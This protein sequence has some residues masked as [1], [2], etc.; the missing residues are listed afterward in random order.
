MADA[1]DDR[2]SNPM[3]EKAKLSHIDYLRKTERRKNS[4]QV[5]TK[6][7]MRR[8]ERLERERIKKQKEEQLALIKANEV[9]YD[10]EG[11]PIKVKKSD[12]RAISLKARMKVAR[13]L[14]RMYNELDEEDLKEQEEAAAKEKREKEKAAALRAKVKD[15]VDEGGEK[16]DEG[17]KNETDDHANQ[18][19]GANAIALQMQK[20]HL[21]QAANG[22][23]KARAKEERKKKEAAAKRKKEASEKKLQEVKLPNAIPPGSKKGK[24][25]FGVV[26]KPYAG[27]AFGTRGNYVEGMVYQ[28]RLTRSKQ[29]RGGVLAQFFDAGKSFKPEEEE[30]EDDLMSIEATDH[31]ALQRCAATLFNLSK[32]KQNIQG[33]IDEG[34]IGALVSLG[35]NDDDSICTLVAGAFANMSATPFASSKIIN[36]NATETIVALSHSRNERVRQFCCKAIFNLTRMPGL[37]ANLVSQGILGPI[38][39]LRGDGKEASHTCVS[40]VFNLSCVSSTY[41]RME[42]VVQ[43]T[44]TIV[45]AINEGVQVKGIERYRDELLLCAKAF[46]NYSK[47]EGFRVRLMEEGLLHP[48]FN[49]C[50]IADDNETKELC[51]GV[52]FDLSQSSRNRPAMIREKTLPLLLELTAL[53]NESIKQNCAGALSQ[54]ALSEANQSNVIS[55]GLPILLGLAKS[56]NY[57]TLITCAN[58]LAVLSGTRRGC[59]RLV[60]AGAIEVLVGMIKRDR[61]SG[62][63]PLKRCITSG[64]G[65]LLQQNTTDDE[66]LRGIIPILVNLCRL[67]DDLITEECVIVL[68]K[69]SLRKAV[70]DALSQSAAVEVLFDILR[71]A[72]DET[73]TQ[74][75]AVSTVCNIAA[76]DPKQLPRIKATGGI[77]ILLRL[78]SSPT[79]RIQEDC[80]QTLC[81][82]ADNGD[83]AREI[84][85]AGLSSLIA[86]A[87]G[88]GWVTKQWCSAILCS[89]SF[90][91]STRVAQ[92]DAGVRNALITLSHFKDQEMAERCATAF[93]NLTCNPVAADKI[94]DKDTIKTLLSLGGA[95]SEE[96][97]ASCARSLCNLSAR[98]G[99]EKLMV[100][101][102]TVPDLM[103]MAL[104]RSESRTTKR[105]CAKT[106]MNILVPETMESMFEYGV[107][108]AFSS[109]AKIELTEGQSHDDGMVLA[110]ATAFHNIS[111]NPTGRDRILGDKVALQAIF[112][113][114]YEGNHNVKDI[115]WKTLWNIIPIQERHIDLIDARLLHR[116][117]N[118]AVDAQSAGAQQHYHTSGNGMVEQVEDAIDLNDHVLTMIFNLIDEDNSRTLEKEELM[119]A[120]NDNQQVLELLHTSKILRPLLKPELYEE[121]FLH[122]E[123]AHEG[124]VTYAEFKSFI[125]TVVT[126]A[127]KKEERDNKRKRRS[128]L[129]KQGDENEAG[130]YS[131]KVDDGEKKT[132]LWE[133]DYV[134]RGKK[135]INHAAIENLHVCLRAK[136]NTKSISAVKKDPHES[137][138]KPNTIVY[139]AY[140]GSDML[141]DEAAHFMC[142][143]GDDNDTVTFQSSYGPYLSVNSSDNALVSSFS[144][145]TSE[146]FEIISGEADEGEVVHLYCRAVDKFV[147]AIDESGFSET[148]GNDTAFEVLTPGWDYE[149]QI[150]EAEAHAK[151]IMNNCAKAIKCLARNSVNCERL[152]AEG[153]MSILVA[154]SRAKSSETKL[155]ISATI[156]MFAEHPLTR[157]T[158]VAEGAMATIE[159]LSKTQNLQILEN[160]AKTL[161]MLSLH[162]ENAP[163]VVQQGFSSIMEEMVH[164]CSQNL[165]DPKVKEIAFNIIRTIQ[166]ISRVESVRLRMIAEEIIPTV[167][168]ALDIV[169]EKAYVDVIICITNFAELRRAR[170]SIVI[171]GATEALVKIGLNAKTVEMQQRVAIVV[172]Y[173]SSVNSKS[174][175]QAMVFSNVMKLIAVLARGERMETKECISD[176]IASLSRTKEVRKDMV[177]QGALELVQ[178]LAECGSEVAR[179]NCALTMTKIST[180]VTRMETG[181]V[182]TL[183]DL[184][185][186][187]KAKVSTDEKSGVIENLETDDGAIEQ[188]NAVMR[189]PKRV[190]MP[191]KVE[192]DPLSEEAKRIELEAVQ[193]ISWT[194]IA[195]NTE[196]NPPALPDF[197]GTEKEQKE[198]EKLSRGIGY[199]D[200]PM[201]AS[202]DNEETHLSKYEVIYKKVEN[203]GHSIEKALGT[204]A[205]NDEQMDLHVD[206]SD[207]EGEEKAAN[208]S[209]LSDLYDSKRI[210]VRSRSGVRGSPRSSVGDS[211]KSPTLRKK[212][213]FSF[214]DPQQLE[215]E[216]R[217][218][219]GKT[220]PRI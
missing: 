92:V 66:T 140:H 163:V 126:A 29:K 150:A 191:P 86:L 187:P 100:E 167:L 73:P 12:K 89:L 136:A 99:V 160:C 121:A 39:Q 114:L 61:E 19:A 199:R 109:L 135:I 84:V 72:K 118:L 44:I 1:D 176:A 208:L 81:S 168:A 82:L 200:Q 54:L 67:G 182:S 179:R 205:G 113:F 154:L 162:E 31:G 181:T 96:T 115:C 184:C 108:W 149:A 141:N 48:I 111:C 79:P 78:V 37:E 106:L 124:H 21:Q 20:I 134:S 145:G 144:I 83:C 88:N 24:I 213:S 161:Y 131:Y 216:M 11:N 104:V 178:E 49:M 193:P 55:Q 112:F 172:A 42:K 152:V 175:R 63:S 215:T 127:A 15:N 59:Q 188:L 218:P 3:L 90:D 190:G 196:G 80:A 36:D 116:M 91:D 51:S 17:E 58:T 117:E 180:S 147:S 220:L 35:K 212:S 189:L 151:T 206:F 203:L 186:T 156:T 158:I 214:V 76:G 110:C 119:T 169:G 146:M 105:L 195:D 159:I 157:A 138:E 211:P 2:E 197:L 185:M 204:L 9:Q 38:I 142:W 7:A 177:D 74:Q 94:A 34:S 33:M 219:G 139:K 10:A 123:T 155:L 198:I 30:E 5:A 75:A 122:L 132:K 128:Q 18:S 183:I 32:F 69:I 13:A 77:P 194:K 120:V 14:R 45:N 60:K 165:S 41:M 102:K 153:A 207:D 28:S 70:L 210:V 97:R 171:G 174:M 166:Y 47:I 93:C 125:L 98:P 143:M 64:L 8:D 50:R 68:Y 148:M 101:S 23:L 173:I 25:P 43:T 65:N 4:A 129:S 192:L 217:L 16:K 137:T 85:T 209:S 87:D 133:D 27:D 202:G 130:D 103:V 107:V 62:P 46:K 71:N 6:V 52:L 40:S 201:G 164:C 57:D 53:D 95:Y 56:D 170:K 26:F 22:E